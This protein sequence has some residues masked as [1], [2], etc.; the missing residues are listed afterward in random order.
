MLVAFSCF[1]L[2]WGG[3]HKCYLDLWVAF[4]SRL[5]ARNIGTHF[6]FKCKKSI[7]T[8]LSLGT[9]AAG[10]EHETKLLGENQ[11]ISDLSEYLL[12]YDIQNTG[13]SSIKVSNFALK[14][15]RLF[16]RICI[17]N[18]WKPLDLHLKFVNYSFIT[19]STHTFHFFLPFH[20]AL[21]GFVI[22]VTTDG[23]IMYVSD[24]I[25]PLLGH[26]PVSNPCTFSLQSRWAQVVAMD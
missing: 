24:S 2:K 15:P 5:N 16:L 10:K 18:Y 19:T 4:N 17:S 13:I 11:T 26:L 12:S 25:T 14:P 9:A 23:S 7:V 3:D 8:W 6:S 1:L 21:D 22:A 20:Q